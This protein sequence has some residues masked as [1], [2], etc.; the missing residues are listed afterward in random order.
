MVG[1]HSF[2]TDL[3]QEIHFPKLVGLVLLSTRSIDD[4][5]LVMYLTVAHFYPWKAGIAIHSENTE[6][7]IQIVIFQIL[8]FIV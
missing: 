5:Q 8:V 2:N 7:K 6:I 3:P 1:L 4:D